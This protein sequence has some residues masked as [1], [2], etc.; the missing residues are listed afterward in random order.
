CG[1]S[2]SVPRQ[3][4]SWTCLFDSSCKTSRWR[5]VSF[6]SSGISFVSI[7]SR[8]PTV[9]LGNLGAKDKIFL[10]SL[11][12]QLRPALMLHNFSIGSPTREDEKALVGGG[13]RGS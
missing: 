6:C 5:G 2:C 8:K 12:A 3:L 11:L 10:T 13:G 1:E 7:R 9:S 4:P